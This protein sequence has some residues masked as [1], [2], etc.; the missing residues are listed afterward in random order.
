MVSCWYTGETNPQFLAGKRKQ[1]PAAAPGRDNPSPKCDGKASYPPRP[2]SDPIFAPTPV[3]CR[4]FPQDVRL[5]TDWRE[6]VRLFIHSFTHSLTHQAL[7]HAFSGSGGAWKC[8]E[9]SHVSSYEP[10]AR[11]QALARHGRHIH[12][13]DKF[14][15]ST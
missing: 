9:I 2:P 5:A 14:V 4:L 10:P 1:G 11:C 3:R 13:F 15:L 6:C 12:S 7:I 8:R